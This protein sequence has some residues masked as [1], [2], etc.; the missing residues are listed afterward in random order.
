MIKQI[1]L[2]DDRFEDEKMVDLK[3][4]NFI[5]G[6]NGTGKTSIVEAI[7]KQYD[8]EYDI[9]VFQG[10]ES[11]LSDN[12]ELNAITLGEINT[13]LQPLI[14][15]KKEIIKELNN[16]ITEPKH[17]EKNTYSEFIKAKYSHSKLENKLD[18]FYSNS[19]SKIKNEHPEWTGPNYKKGNFEQDIDNAKVLT[20]SDLNKYKEQESQNTINIGEKKYFYEPEY[21]EITET[22]N[23]LITRNITKYAIQ[24]FSSNEEMNWVKEGL[25]IHKDK[26]QC[27]FCGSKLED[28]R[29]NDLSLYFND[30]V[31]L[32]EQEID[33]TIKEIQ[34]SSKTVE[35]NVE[36]NEKF[37]Y[38]EYHDEIKRL[39]DKI[40]NI[41]IESNNYFKELINSLNKRKENIFYH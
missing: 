11:V 28:K 29:I 35:K 30:E 41:I 24:K 4:K 16:D 3:R 36:I 18:K 5:F 6:K 8:N 37:F 13:E 34:E 26:T 10:F 40:G 21:K 31:K 19:A 17:K 20:Q 14:N 25:S 22:V 39:N 12:G 7:L 23:N 1:S 15:K 9:R 27:A 38:P 2:P 32:L 33:N